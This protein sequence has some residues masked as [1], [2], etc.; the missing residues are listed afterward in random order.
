[1]I[2]NLRYVITHGNLLGFPSP[3]QF[4]ICFD[5]VVSAFPHQPLPVNNQSRVDSILERICS[6]NDTHITDQ[7]FKTIPTYYM[8]L[9]R[10]ENHQETIPYT[11]WYSGKTINSEFEELRLGG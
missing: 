9:L 8:E 3:T 2:Q 1:M 7:H 6:A 11:D 4:R 5:P 10:I